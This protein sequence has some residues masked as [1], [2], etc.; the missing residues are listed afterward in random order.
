MLTF[1]IRSVA[2]HEHVMS[3]LFSVLFI[4][5]TKRQKKIL[6]FLFIKKMKI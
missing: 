3:V 4:F 1:V 5:G 6:K 2:V